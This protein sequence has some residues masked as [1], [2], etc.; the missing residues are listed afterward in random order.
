[1]GPETTFARRMWVAF[2]VCVLVMLTMYCDPKNRAPF[3]SQRAANGQKIFHPLG[4]LVTSMREQP[5]VS[6]T[7]SKA[8][9][10]P[11]QNHRKQKCFPTEEEQRGHCA[12]VERNHD[13]GGDPNDRLRKRSVVRQD[14]WHS[15]IVPSLSLDGE[16]VVAAPTAR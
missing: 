5:M 6:D 7:Y 8:S 1:M 14:L 3:Q 15:H 12:Y 16:V 4:G 13:E 10:D 2:L 11:P 9:G